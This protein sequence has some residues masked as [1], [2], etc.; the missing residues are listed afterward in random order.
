MVIPPDCAIT[1]RQILTGACP[2]CGAEVNVAG[3][4]PGGGIEPSP[5]LKW[6]VTRMEDDVVSGDELTRVITLKNLCERPPGAA[7]AIP[8][9]RLAMADPLKNVRDVALRAIWEVSC[10]LIQ[11]ASSNSEVAIARIYRIWRRWR[12][13]LVVYF[14]CCAESTSVPMPGSNS[15]L[16]RSNTFRG[17][18]RP[19]PAHLCFASCLNLMLCRTT[20]QGSSGFATSTPIPMTRNCLPCAAAFF[21][22][23]ERSLS[24][25]FCSA[26]VNTL[27]HTI[28]N[29]QVL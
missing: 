18:D 10:A 26:D 7:A 29:G 3:L 17:L 2:R 9:L 15:S 11:V 24:V 4:S 14:R 23:S 13:F 8:I 16:G 19:A 22:G 25:D 5:E 21:S 27:S 1:H 28:L 12:W 6:N 20:R